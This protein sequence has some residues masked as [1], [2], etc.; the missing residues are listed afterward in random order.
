M[1][2]DSNYPEMKEQIPDDCPKPLGK[3]LLIWAYV[4]ADFAGDQLTRRS[5]T[6]FTVM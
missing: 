3:E 6:E 4:G 1:V 5:W 2:F